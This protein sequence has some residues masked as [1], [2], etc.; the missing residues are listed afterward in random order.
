MSVDRSPAAD[1]GIDFAVLVL[2]ALIVLALGILM[3]V[4]ATPP[5]TYTPQHATTTE[6]TR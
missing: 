5:A 3:V 6:V 1:W 4:R 2:G